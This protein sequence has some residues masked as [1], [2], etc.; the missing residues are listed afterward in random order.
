M[1]QQPWPHPLLPLRKSAIKLNLAM[2]H[3]AQFVTFLSLIFYMLGTLGFAVSLKPVLR[4][5]NQGLAELEASVNSLRD[6]RP[7]MA[8][9]HHGQLAKMQRH[10]RN[11]SEL[12]SLAFVF[13]G[14]GAV[15][16]VLAMFL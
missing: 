9:E 4:R 16:Q 7:S 14:A 3:N 6:G 5:I 1:K 8:N 2:S 13:T 15:L 12:S 11:S 10:E